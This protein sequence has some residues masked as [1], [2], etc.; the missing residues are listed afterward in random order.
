[1]FKFTTT[2]KI[3]GLYTDM[4][5]MDKITRNQ[6]LTKTP[7]TKTKFVRVRGAGLFKMFT[8]VNK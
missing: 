7:K 6:R 8:R 2:P 3:E 5:T 1:M 4:T